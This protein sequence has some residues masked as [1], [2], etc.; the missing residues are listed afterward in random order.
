VTRGSK[1]FQEAV[2]KSVLCF[3]FK[4]EFYRWAVVAQSR[5]V[6]VIRDFSLHFE[7]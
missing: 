5:P 2:K 1:I 3:V 4:R 7:S 6:E